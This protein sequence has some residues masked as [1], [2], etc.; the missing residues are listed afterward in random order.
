MFLKFLQQIISNKTDYIVIDLETSGLST[1][2]A[3]II[4]ISA[5]KVKD[6]KIIAQYTSLVKPKNKLNEKSTQI[7]KITSSMLLNARGIEDVFPEFIDF[8]GNNRL[9]GYNISTFDIPIIR[10]IANSLNYDFNNDYIDVLYLAREKMSF[11]P[12]CSLSTVAAYFVIDTT[13]SHRALRDCEITKSCYEHLL[14]FNP[15]T[16]TPRAPKQYRP[17]HTD[18]TKALQQLHALLLGIIADDVLTE[19]EV[20]ILNTWLKDNANLK[21]QF[22]YD[23]VETVV[24][25]ALADG[26]LEQSELDEMLLLFKEY[27]SPISSDNFECHGLCDKAFCLTVNFEYGEKKE[28][29]LLIT[30][31]GGIIKSSVS[32]KTD[33]LVVGSL[34]SPDWNC[35]NYGAKIKKAKEVQES[36]GKIKIITEADL[37]NI[38]DINN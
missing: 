5:I 21:G 37:F 29:E 22:P 26:I 17:A 15:P 6:S 31:H 14:T 36:G 8:I 35:G 16:T 25:E 23:R 38:I 27:T 19:S 7:N 28:V 24:N 4:E 34:G 32:S 13:G 1:K 3:E 12:N 33:F 11:L 20:N 18:Q 10:R 9:L 30:Q 2:T